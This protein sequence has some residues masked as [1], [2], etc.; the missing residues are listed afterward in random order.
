[1]SFYGG[2]VERSVFPRPSVAD[3]VAGTSVALVLIPQSL[4]YAE[5]AGLPPYLGLYAASLPL[6]VFAL[7]ASSPYLQTGPVAVTSLLT[8]SALPDVPVDELVGLA[9]L[10]AV[11]VGVFRLLLGVGRL[12]RIVKLMCAPVVMGFTSGAA[13]IIVASQLPKT[14]GSKPPEGSVM[15]G[16]LW[17]LTN[18]SALSGSAMALAALTL[19][20][21]I[22]G[23]RLHPLFP[24][25]LIAVVV[26]IVWS[27]SLD[28]QGVIV[29]SVP[30]GLP[31]LGL[32]LPWGQTGT[33]L[34]GA[35]VIALVGFAEP[36]SIARSFANET[37]ETWDAN[38]ELVAS[39]VANLVAAACGAYPV[40]GSFSRSSV[41]RLAGAKTRCSGG[42]TGLV[43]LAFL[44]FASVLEPLPTAVLGAIVC[45]AAAKLVKP[46][47][48]VALWKRSR[49]QALL[50][51]STAASVLLLAPRIERAVL[52]GI[53]LTVI[54]HL[55]TGFKLNVRHGPDGL[56][57]RPTGL[58][59]TANIAN[60]TR[61]IEVYL[62]EGRFEAYAPDQVENRAD[63]V[64][65]D[66]S[67]MAFVDEDLAD[68][69]G[70]LAGRFA[71]QGRTL[72]WIHEP[73]SSTKLL[74]S[75]APS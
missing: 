75:A 52:V 16:A 8:L 26:G 6:L 31:P 57:L 42:F 20:L 61:Q 3:A 21:F 30:E 50:A 19:V 44:P 68:A 36:A 69:L 37:G 17:S 58:L 72:R 39:G 56:V 73:A 49:L 27:R 60:L 74:A 35:L 7:L 23:R 48:L 13:V 47:Q 65:I 32:S 43:V 45:G 34:I 63:D 59:W 22:G 33:L 53:V 67:E 14:L 54:V 15:T 4:A 70:R 29:G 25:V 2:E 55:A 1:M 24:G 11:L 38:R 64:V 9:S 51:W 66:L 12:G 40:G 5:L 28:Y 41:N 62:D 46:V 10:M 71:D 18:P